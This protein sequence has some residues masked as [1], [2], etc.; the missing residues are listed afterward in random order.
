MRR[1]GVRRDAPDARGAEYVD[2]LTVRR[3]VSECVNELMAGQI[4]QA[5]AP[6]APRPRMPESAVLL[7]GEYGSSSYT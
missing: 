3:L 5:P 2:A 7:P 4:P 1:S 6:D